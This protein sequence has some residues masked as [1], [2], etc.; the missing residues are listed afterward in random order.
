MVWVLIILRVALV[1][2][3]VVIARQRRR[4]SCKRASALSTAAAGRP[5]R[6]ASGRGGA[7]RAARA[8]RATRDPRARAGGAGAL[9]RPV[10]RS[11]AHLRRSA[12]A[13]VGEADSLVS[14]VDDRARLP[15]EDDFDRRAADISV[16]LPVVV[17]NYRAAH[18]ISRP[19]R[20]RRGEHRRPAAGD[21]PLPGALLTSCRRRRSRRRAGIREHQPGEGIMSRPD[22]PLATLRPQSLGASGRSTRAIRGEPRLTQRDARAHGQAP[23][24][25]ADGD[26]L[27]AARRQP[28][29]ALE[30]QVARRK[31]GATLDGLTQKQR[32]A[33]LRTPRC[34]STSCARPSSTA[35]C[36]EASA[37]GSSP[38]RSTARSR[39]AALDRARPRVAADARPE[40][41]TTFRMVDLLLFA[42]EGK[43]TLLAP[44]GTQRQ[45]RRAARPAAACRA[46]SGPSRRG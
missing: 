41:S 42:F 44:V 15:V 13:A 18:E 34:G 33:P 35:A 40:L 45:P 31:N 12:R 39:A 4:S 26:V 5:R 38:R 28:A 19:R 17:E 37:R 46:G 43:K 10:A 24:R 20:R 25:P 23:H 27:K 21:D 16:E 29:R 2:A 36:C 7:A 14:E 30:A 1:A 22:D 32:T 9:R 8:T 11:A 3:G 6:P